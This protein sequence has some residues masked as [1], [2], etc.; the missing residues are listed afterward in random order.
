MRLENSL[1]REALPT[2]IPGTLA[3]RGVTICQELLPA[4]PECLLLSPV[5]AGV[6]TPLML[7]SPEGASN[8]LPSPHHRDLR[9]L[10]AC[11]A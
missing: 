7:S 5:A 3:T 6:P 11:Q 2:Q 1:S 4:G 10:E 8:R 9:D